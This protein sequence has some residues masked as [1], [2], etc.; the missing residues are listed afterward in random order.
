MKP[1]S[2]L[3]KLFQRSLLFI[4]GCLFVYSAHAQNTKKVDWSK[5]DGVG[6]HSYDWGTWSSGQQDMVADEYGNLYSIGAIAGPSWGNGNKTLEFDSLTITGQS[7]YSTPYVAKYDRHGKVLWAI[8]ID[9]PAGGYVFV[10]SLAIDTAGAVYIVGSTYWNSVSSIAGFP[11]ASYQGG[12]IWMLKVSSEGTPLW[13]QTFGGS[14][15]DYPTGITCSPRGEV[16]LTGLFETYFQFGTSGISGSSSGW[17]VFLLKLEADGTPVY[18]RKIA[19]ASGQYAYYSAGGDVVVDRNNNLYV[20]GSFTGDVQVAGKWMSAGSTINDQN[21]FVMKILATQGVP[22]WSMQMGYSAS[23]LAVADDG[24]LFVAGKTLY[25]CDSFGTYKLPGTVQGYGDDDLFVAKVDPSG[26]IDWLKRLG[27]RHMNFSWCSQYPWY[28]SRIG[29]SSLDVDFEGKVLISGKIDRSTDSTSLAQIKIP[30]Y[31]NTNAYSWYQFGSDAFMIKITPNGDYDWHLRSAVRKDSGT[32]YYYDEQTLGGGVCTDNAGAI[33]WKSKRAWSYFL[34]NDTMKLFFDNDTILDKDRH[35]VDRGSVPVIWAIR[36]NMIEVDSFTPLTACP[37]DSITVYYSKYNEFNIGN[38]F[39]AKISNSTGN[40]FN[41][42]E[43]GSVTDTGS[44]VIRG[45]IPLELDFG[46]GYRIRVDGTSP[47]VRGYPSYTP[48]H[49]K[50]KP[51]TNA[52]ID[53]EFCYGDTVNLNPLGGGVEFAWYRDPTLNDTSLYQPLVYPVDTTRYILFS[54]DSI[55]RCYN[56]DTV[57]VNVLPNPKALPR[58]D[59]T[60][61]QGESV[62]LYSRGQFGRSNLYSY[63]WRNKGDNSYIGFGDSVLVSPRKTTTY[64]VILYDS[65]SIIRDTVPVTINVRLHLSANPRS[66]TLLCNGQP[67]NVYAKT[68]GGY[69]A[70]YQYAWY[71]ADTVLLSNDSAWVWPHVDTTA[72]LKLVVQDGC[73]D[74]ND[75]AYFKA[76]RRGKINA[77]TRSDTTI[78]IGEAISLNA[79]GT[80]GY[81]GGYQF[82]WDHGLASIDSVVVQPSNTTTYRLILSDNCS[83]IEDTAFVTINVRQPV[84]VL[85]RSDSTICKG[86]EVLLH[87]DGT[88]GDS[89]HYTYTWDGIGVGNNF[90]VNP[91]TTKL[92]KVTLTDNCS[93]QTSED[94]VL[95][96]VRA[97]LKLTH[98]P[99]TLLCQEAAAN[100]RAWGTGGVPSQYSFIWDDGLVSISLPANTAYT[101][102]PQFPVQVKVKLVDNCTVEG[103]SAYI[104]VNLRPALVGKVNVLDTLVCH[105]A[106]V[107]LKASAVGGLVGA[108]NYTWSNLGSGANKT[109]NPL[110]DKQYT[111]IV[112]DGCSPKDTVFVQLRTRTPLSVMADKDTLICPEVLTDIKAVASGGLGGSYQYYWNQSLGQG[113]VQGVRPAS[114]TSYVVRASDNCSIDAYDTIVVSTAPQPTTSYNLSTTI[115]CQPLLVTFDALY[116][117]QGGLSSWKWVFGDG[118]KSVTTTPNGSHTYQTAGT[119]SSKLIVTSDYG[120]V[121][122]SFEVDVLVHPKP[123]ASFVANPQKAL[124]TDPTVQFTNKSSYA[125]SYQWDMGDGVGTSTAVNPKYT[126]TDTGN[127]PV[128]LVAVSDKGCTDEFIDDYRIHEIYTCFIPN[129]F[130]PNGDHDNDTFG[131]N[132]TGARRYSIQVFDRW[133]ALVFETDETH[134]AWNGRWDNTG[135]LLPAGAYAYKVSVYLDEGGRKNYSGTVVLI[136]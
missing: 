82:D 93:H 77:F 128:K 132:I 74:E 130:T 124:I 106:T 8:P 40:F 7:N 121:D 4:L 92:Y 39:V 30:H 85:V 32:V 47:G 29:I 90:L 33:Y 117:N 43:L 66:D 69:P 9:V 111:M 50:N 91:P 109:V 99:D 76:F 127:F 6:A 104:N 10:T 24:K 87:V 14:G 72:V 101:S 20:S 107:N 134:R 126:Y 44:G 112:D 22:I 41:A 70:G 73:S 94:S 131:L 1:N 68:T 51:N 35:T 75:S 60:I 86:E 133:G 62:W 45:K 96:T 113:Q 102:A 27:D 49:L 42:L 52:G 103:D 122:S 67:V 46:T 64:N 118:N 110:S 88:G 81:K 114:Q 119:H 115:G 89:L 59:T 78:C 125:V 57:S 136:R 58:P 28:C 98:S 54:R 120:C 38:K 105:G 83:N 3:L 34:S 97:P 31:N 53:M 65:C 25:G 26:S 116:Q 2:H 16:Y 11:V 18:G 61:C 79:W 123:K 23:A 36:E 108:Y 71:I 12:D 84:T 55:T 5:V 37:G 15:Q 48:L 63:H 95:I 129:A 21:G 100:L 19:T 17:S 135:D 80:G 13:A 56:L